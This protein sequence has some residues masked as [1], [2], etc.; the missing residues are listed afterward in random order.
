MP[1]VTKK[2]GDRRGSEA[3]GSKSEKWC[4]L[5]YVN[6]KFTGPDC[7]LN[8]MLE[9][10]ENAMKEQGVNSIMRW[11]ALKQIPRLERWKA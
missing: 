1:L 3:N 7:S 11:M 4:E 8:Q 5:C 9:I 6:G 10:V 2:Q